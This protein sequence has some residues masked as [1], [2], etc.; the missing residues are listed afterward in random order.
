MC[1]ETGCE[2][3]ISDGDHRKESGIVKR[4]NCSLRKLNNQIC[5]TDH[6]LPLT[7]IFCKATYAK[8]H[9]DKK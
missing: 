3:V 7:V 5:L 9:H 2:L 4:E 8:K 6:C 1:N